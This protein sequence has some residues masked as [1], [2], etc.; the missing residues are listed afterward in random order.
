[1]NSQYCFCKNRLDKRLTGVAEA[2]TDKSAF[3][4]R[5]GFEDTVHFL[6]AL[7][8]IVSFV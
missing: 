8:Y 4:P 6:S 7:L 1:M 2:E 5:E 3:G